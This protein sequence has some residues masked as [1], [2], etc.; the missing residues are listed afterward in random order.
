LNAATFAPCAFVAALLALG[1][2]WVASRWFPTGT[3]RDAEI[4]PGA[5]FDAFVLLVGGAVIFVAVVVRVAFGTWRQTLAVAQR[6]KAQRSAWLDRV[7]NALTPS[8]ATGVRWALGR[9]DDTRAPSRAGVLGAVVGVAGLLAVVVYVAGIDHVVSTPS[10]YGW[11]F[12]ASAG[13]GDDPSQIPPLRDFVLRQR[14]IA[15]VAIVDIS[16]AL[17]TGDGVID[18]EWAYEDVRGHIGP[19]V[20]K[21]RAPASDDEVMIGTKTASDLG[22]HIGDELRVPRLHGSPVALRVVGYTLFPTVETDRFTRGIVVTRRTFAQLHTSG[23]YQNVVLRWKPGTDVDEEVARL[24]EE[25]TLG[26]ALA[27]PTSDVK[28]LDAVRNYPRWLAAF[29]VVLGILATIHALVV[30]SRRRRHEMGVLRALGFSRRQLAR[31]VSTHG[32][33]IGVCAVVIGVPLGLA[34]GRWLWVTH[35]SNIGLGTSV[36]APRIIVAAVAL[37]TIVLTWGIAAI[38]GRRAIRAPLT[39]ALRVE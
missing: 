20:V 35:A 27:A 18:Q 31:A 30:S 16:G 4:D 1:A 34:A 5:Q 36:Y 19:S 14:S 7:T 2:A 39:T 15:D 28:N 32:V 6:Q 37:G 8:S 21:G 22:L 17:P 38:T 33:T 12:D 9:R 25:R 10:A 3:T 29:L 26:G 13:G 11:S 23:P 24:S